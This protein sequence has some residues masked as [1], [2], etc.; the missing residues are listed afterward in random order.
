MN[1]LTAW[2]FGV[3]GHTYYEIGDNRS[4]SDDGQFYLLWPAGGDF[5]DLAFGDKLQ[6]ASEVLPANR[7]HIVCSDRHAVRPTTRSHHVA[8]RKYTLRH[9]DPPPTASQGGAR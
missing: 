2:R 7:H 6:A 3:I 4:L 5:P 1:I 8:A 9:A